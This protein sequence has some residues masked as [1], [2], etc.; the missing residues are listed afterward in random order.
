MRNNGVRQRPVPPSLIRHFE[1][2]RPPHGTWDTGLERATR[3][4]S[5]F[6]TVSKARMLPTARRT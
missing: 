1:D 3:S 5:P 6:W 2:D 4:R